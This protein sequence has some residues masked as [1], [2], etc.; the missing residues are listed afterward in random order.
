MPPRL[1]SNGVPA[2]TDLPPSAV[3]RCPPTCLPHRTSTAPA[4]PGTPSPGGQRT[5]AIARLRALAALLTSHTQI[6]TEPDSNRQQPT[7]GL[8]SPLRP[9]APERNSTAVASPD[10][11]CQTSTRTRRSAVAGGFP[12]SCPLSVSA[13]LCASS[14]PPTGLAA[15]AVRAPSRPSLE[16]SYLRV[17]L[18]GGSGQKLVAS[19]ALIALRGSRLLPPIRGAADFAQNARGL[20]HRRPARPVHLRLRRA[21]LVLVGGQPSPQTRNGLFASQ[22]PTF[23]GC[24]NESGVPVTS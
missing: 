24:R 23:T 9:T 13:S 20:R 18:P 21:G 10:P 1:T 2:K 16:A 15:Q 11:P 12:V 17:H 3:P 22:L 7:P 6:P 14:S 8:R 4:P 19:A 5:S